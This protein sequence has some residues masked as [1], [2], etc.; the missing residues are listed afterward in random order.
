MVLIYPLHRVNGGEA[1][2]F[3]AA[4]FD[5]VADPDPWTGISLHWSDGA[6]PD[7]LMALLMWLIPTGLE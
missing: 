2:L 4:K 1:A 5:R 6:V 7:H 3:I